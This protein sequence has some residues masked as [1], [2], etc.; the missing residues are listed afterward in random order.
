MECMESLARAI[1]LDDGRRMDEKWEFKMFQTLELHIACFTMA[2]S[3]FS[4]NFSL[5][6][7]VDTNTDSR[8]RSDDDGVIMTDAASASVSFPAPVS[9]Q[10]RLPFAWVDDQ[11]LVP[12]LMERS[13][14][15]L[16]YSDIVLEARDTHTD[17]SGLRKGDRYTLRCVDLTLSSYSQRPSPNSDGTGTAIG[18]AHSALGGNNDA[19]AVA[20]SAAAANNS[21]PDIDPGLYEGGGKVW[22]CSI[23]LLQYLIDEEITLHGLHLQKQTQ[24]QN[25]NEASTEIGSFRNGATTA[26]RTM[27]TTVSAYAE[28]DGEVKGPVDGNNSD[29]ICRRLFALELGCGHGLPGCHLLREAF[30]SIEHGGGRDGIPIDVVVIFVDYNNSVVL[31][32]TI[33]NIV[34]NCNIAPLQQ[35]PD[36]ESSN[37]LDRNETSRC[38]PEQVNAHVL[39]G[40]GDWMDMSK[41]LQQHDV[42]EMGPSTSRTT[43]TTKLPVDGTFDLIVA[44]ETMYSEAAARDTALLLY[45]HLR[46]DV[47]VAFVATKRYYFGVNGGVD[48]FRQFAATLDDCNSGDNDDDYRYRLHIETVRT[49]D[50]GSGNI[51]EILRVQRVRSS[52]G[53]YR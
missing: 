28:T 26:P 2:S 40:A 53:D 49:I 37:E 18:D 21:A 15:E 12:L 8:D 29:D 24:I 32:A 41:Q 31:D 11:Q 3:A 25:G 9:P 17:T 20:P 7:A 34:L 44:A 19:T 6:G 33:S 43:G 14:E 46:R 22:E 52:D 36:T 38:T 42:L 13:Q 27:D 5:E 50:N 4:F 35:Q 16:V 47:G 39:L 1:N 48:P 51:R 10:L 30:H 23:D 45:R